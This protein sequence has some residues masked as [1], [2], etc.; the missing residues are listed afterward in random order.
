M[1][2]IEGRYF[3]NQNILVTMFFLEV[4][5]YLHI[6]FF[7]KPFYWKTIIIKIMLERTQ[8]FYREEKPH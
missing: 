4:I 1:M 5:I 2:N 6:Y 3:I 8:L 7:I